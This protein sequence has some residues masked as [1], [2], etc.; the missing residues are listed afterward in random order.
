M[1]SS[2]FFKS[3]PLWVCFGLTSCGVNDL[4][5]WYFVEGVVICHEVTDALDDVPDLDADIPQECTTCPTSHDHDC[6]WVHFIYVEFH[7]EP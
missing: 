1:F 4:Y 3:Q 5:F 6:F 2:F 7:G